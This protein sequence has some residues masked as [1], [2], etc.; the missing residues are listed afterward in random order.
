MTVEDYIK[1]EMPLIKSIVRLVAFKF[2][3]DREELFQETM[4]RAWLKNDKY[5]DHLGINGFKSWI[6]QIAF[7]FAV[8]EFRRK[9]HEFMDLRF[10]EDILYVNQRVLEHRQEIAAHYRNLRRNFHPRKALCLY[11]ATQ[12]YKMEEIAK[13]QNTKKQAIKSLLHDA[14]EYVRGNMI[15]KNSTPYRKMILSK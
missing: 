4:L 13:M 11:L 8:D 12:G 5:E 6:Y 15:L 3:C 14:R 7:N 1:T 10:A 9:S 2:K